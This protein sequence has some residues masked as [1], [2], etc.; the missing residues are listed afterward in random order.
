MASRTHSR[1]APPVKEVVQIEPIPIR[2]SITGVELTQATQFFNFNGQ[3]TGLAADNSVPLVANKATTL[4][5][6]INHNPA[7]LQEPLRKKVT[8]SITYTFN[9]QPITLNPLNGPL[10]APATN[11]VQRTLVNDTLNFLIPAAH[12]TGSMPIVVNV[13]FV[14][15]SGVPANQ[16]VDAIFEELPDPRMHVVLLHVKAPG[17]EEHDP[18]TCFEALETFSE[19]GKFYPVA[20][21]NFTGF[22]VVTITNN[23][24]EQGGSG[25]TNGFNPIRDL[26][27]DMRAASG[28][29]DI[30]VGLLPKDQP[31][32]GRSGCGGGGFALGHTDR[33]TIGHEIGHALG[34]GHTRCGNNGAFDPTYPDVPGLPLGSILEVGLSTSDMTTF[35]PLTF[36]DVMGACSPIWISP[37]NYTR[38]KDRIAQQFAKRSLQPAKGEM[39]VLNIRL[40]KD[41]RVVVRSSFRFKCKGLI[42]DD[43][44]SGVWCDLLDA[45]GK[46]L[47]SY[48]CQ[49]SDAYQTLSDPYLDFHQTI[50]LPRSTRAIAIRRQEAVVATLPLSEEAPK[51]ALKTPRRT[52]GKRDLMRLE[53]QS[54]HAGD[55]PTCLVRYSNDGGKSWRAV[56]AGMTD[57][58][59][60]LDLEMLPGGEDC[61]VQVMA[62]AGLASTIVEQAIGA[63]P[64]K[65]RQARIVS[66]TPGAVL[67]RGESIC[68]CG[69][70]Y[71]PDFGMAPFDDLS[72]KSD[73]D[74]VLGTGPELTIFELKPGNH[75]FTLT[76]PD[77]MGGVAEA[78]VAVTV[79]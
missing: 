27:L 7:L 56:A 26:L 14:D 35:D 75:Q 17:F 61:R 33:H 38:M 42:S 3:G 78:A 22:E 72:W 31:L 73:G 43:A 51:L 60:L 21:F 49:I 18:P 11:E 67:K 63:V 40:H 68:L 46:T 1:L 47:A 5:V 25:C 9:G 62:T 45:N 29:D 57:A 74:S 39:M 34:R 24:N 13:R 12:C 55:S 59:C 2:L 79:V 65:L 10:P 64:Q 70:A 8:G 76:A 69:G 48:P 66:P 36:K 32:T 54:D 23:P 58:K 20:G 52:R 16:T 53:W 30:F 41:N 4:R 50:P 6:Y 77:G 71:S 19:I 28:T 44:S 37:H 15:N